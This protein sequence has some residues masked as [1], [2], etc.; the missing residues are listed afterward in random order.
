MVCFV[1]CVIMINI[2]TE[3]FTN[4]LKGLK[5]YTTQRDGQTTGLLYTPK[6][7]QRHENQ[8]TK[9][10]MQDICFLILQNQS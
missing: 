6:A 1:D 7:L 2:S 4:S 3:K 10:T 5:S 9:V 8:K